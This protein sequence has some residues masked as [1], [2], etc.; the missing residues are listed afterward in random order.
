MPVDIEDLGR[1][2]TVADGAWGTELDR[3]G[4]PAGF[5]RE[6]W[7][8]TRP[9]LVQQ[10]ADS[11]VAAG[12]RILLTNTFGANRYVLG[13][14]SRA[15]HVAAY[16]RAGAEISRRAIGDKGHV[17][18]SIGPSGKIV[19]MG[20]VKPEEL[21]EGF[22]LQAQALA[23]GGADALV[24]ET[25]TEIAEAVAAVRAAKTTGLPVVGSMTF[26]SGKTRT[27]TMMGVTPTQAVNALTDAGADIIGCNCGI[28]IENYIQVAA[29]LRAATD[30]PIWVKANAGLPEIE[31][32]RIVYRMS[33][34]EYATKARELVKAG[35]NI[36]GGCCGTSPE[37]I[38]ALCVSLL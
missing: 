14:H 17:F 8:V 3:L 38:R 26:D 1:R 5:C 35:A 10:V 11:Y 23:D 4:C 22:Q 12:A 16:N 27:D 2:V 15:E 25:M 34:Q 29:M 6:E 28:G 37:F 31:E 18:G 7:N 13:R 19:M 32:G 24:V 20:E 9:E 33:P 36:V 30:K 21:F